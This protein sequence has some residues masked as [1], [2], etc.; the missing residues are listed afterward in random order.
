MVLNIIPESL[1]GCHGPL[2]LSGKELFCLWFKATQ[3]NNLCYR[4]VTKR[5]PAQMNFVKT[6]NP[7]AILT[8]NSIC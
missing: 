6:P 4:S 2:R 3:I 7:E 5:L 8:T 1:T